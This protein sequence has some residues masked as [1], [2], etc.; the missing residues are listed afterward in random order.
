MI[1]RTAS[2]PYQVVGECYL[3]G[4]DNC[5]PFLGPLPDGWIPFYN[6][7]RSGY[8]VARKYRRPSTD[9]STDDDPR[10]PTL[11]EWEP[12]SQNEDSGKFACFRNKATGEEV[13]ADPR[14][15]VKALEAMGLEVEE[16]C[17]V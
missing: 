15:T 3:H 6:K 14:L 17:F 5:V 1:R 13:N 16:F 11:R 9:E 10:L 8:G 7:R 2:N 4:T 12:E